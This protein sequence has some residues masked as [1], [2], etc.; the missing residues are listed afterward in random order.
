MS[1]MA[2]PDQ[3]IISA[4]Y[5]VVA[6]IGIP[7]LGWFLKRFWDS[8]ATKDWVM[9]R[10]REDRELDEQ[11]DNAQIELLRKEMRELKAGLCQQMTSVANDLK[12]SHRVIQEDIKTILK[13]MP[14]TR[15][16]PGH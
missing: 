3:Q 14:R 12:D 7:I 11:K 5:W 4:P 15:P 13:E 9:E 2:T 6:L 8:L 10:L 1:D 16:T